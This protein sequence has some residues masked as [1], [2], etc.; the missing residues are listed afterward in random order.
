MHGHGQA[1]LASVH[2]TTSQSSVLLKSPALPVDESSSSNFIVLFFAMELC[3]S[4]GSSSRIFSVGILLLLIMLVL[5]Q[6][7]EAEAAWTW[8]FWSGGDNSGGSKWEESSSFRGELDESPPGLKNPILSIAKFDIDTSVVL[9]SQN[10]RGRQ[11]VERSTSLMAEHSCWQVAYAS[12]FK[13][14]KEILKDEDRKSRLALRLTDCFL[15]T[16]GR[17]GIKKCADT[18]PVNTCVK[19]LDDHTHAIFLAFFIDAASMCHYLQS[20]EFKHETERLVNELKQSAHTV[21]NKLGNM[22]EQL[23]KQHSAVI[24]HSESILEAQR[25]LQ[26]EHAELQLSIEQGMQHLQEAANEAQRQ[27]DFVSRI[28]KDIAH[29]QQLLADSL[30]SEL[31]ELQEKSSRLGSSMSNLHVSVGELTEKSLAG[32]AQLLEGQAEAMEGLTELQRSQ[33][34]AIEESR[35]SMQE[36]A[37]EA[38]NHQQEFKKWQ[39]ELD[40]MHRR[41]ANGSTAMLKAQESFVLKQAAVF[42]TLEKLFTLHNDILLESRTFKTALVYFLGGIFVFFATTTRHTQNA[43]LVLLVG[44]LMALGFE[45][46]LIMKKAERVPEAAR[47]VWLQYRIFWVRTGYGIFALGILLYSIFTFRDYDKLNYYMLKEIQENMASGKNGGELEC[48]NC[49]QEYLPP[50]APRRLADH[51]G[52]IAK[53]IVRKA[54]ATRTTRVT[55]STTASLGTKAS[56]T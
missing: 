50:P 23:D 26:H 38:Y 47:F 34:E 41:L 9:G 1:T 51:E 18:V 22:N 46:T 56:D 19:A 24:E 45:V 13:S 44:L 7:E 3:R 30:A 37:A 36:L 33:V 53:K 49:Q 31:A 39:S 40:E 15:K 28:Q 43:R 48:R 29:K 21:E 52:D 25:R 20:Q 6:S 5:L 55:R 2:F 27:L 54:R 16:S 10:P 11:F 42:T 12:M 17:C 4:R 35:A 14:C 8:K 32:Q